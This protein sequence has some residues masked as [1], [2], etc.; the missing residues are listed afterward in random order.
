MPPTL[1][2]TDRGEAAAVWHL[3]L[4]S[5]FPRAATTFYITAQCRYFGTSGQMRILITGGA[6]YIGSHTLLSV[7]AADYEACVIDNF[8]NS[9][10]D[11]LTRVGRLSN[12][13]FD[14]HKTDLRDGSAL[15]QSVAAFP[16]D[17]VVHF[18]GLK[19]VGESETHP[20]SYYEQNVF[21]TIQLLQAMD[22]AG[23]RS[24]VFSSSATVY[25]IP[26]YL[27][28]DEAHPLQPANPYGRT[29]FFVEEIIRDWAATD[30]AKGAMLLRYF[31]PVG[32]HES[33]HIGE[34]PMGV[35]NNL[36]PYIARVAV[37][38]LD[39]LQVFGNDYDTDDGTGVRD[40]I[41]VTD[42][43]E[44]HLAA[45]DYLQHHRGVET[46]N[47]GTGSG[48]S[49]LQMIAAFEA[50]SGKNVP[51][52]I[53]PRRKGDIDKFWADPE[54]AHQL[55]GWRARLDIDAMC[56]SVWKWQSQNPSGYGQ[57]GKAE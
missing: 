33:G 25:G 27:P 35:P 5:G 57:G 45:I 38:R 43:A 13:S 50:A 21:G 56:R 7:L 53:A 41:H 47:L 17:I 24:I 37:G 28:Y 9:H 15:T 10:P 51:Y 30:P 52:A 19:A 44:G 14:I 4:S 12:R 3:L 6:G 8:S 32:A 36:M 46:V 55:L 42:L 34:D 1:P 54:R 48:L 22:A 16:P 39:Q 18:A 29:K 26:Q 31:N 40:Y 20:L 49:V 11:A 2:P 23:C